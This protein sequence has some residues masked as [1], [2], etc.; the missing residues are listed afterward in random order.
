[1]LIADFLIAVGVCLAWAF[2]TIVSRIVVTGMDVPPLFYA[3]VRFALVA[4][5]TWPWLL[6]MPRP[7]W[8]LVAVG[9]LIGGASFALMFIGLT[10]ATASSSAIVSQLGVAMTTLLSIVILGEHVHWRRWL[11]IALTFAGAMVVMLDPS[12]LALS[13]GLIFV[14]ASALAGSL[15]A[16]LMKQ[17]EGVRPLQFQAWV[18]L[19]SFP[20]LTLMSAM[21]EN[22]PWTRA[23]AAGWPFLGALLF[24]GLVVSVLSHTAYYRLIQ[25]YDATV[26]APL[27]LMTPI[28]TVALGVMLTGDPIDVSMLIGAGL[29]L[30][31]VLIIALRKNHVMPLAILLRNRI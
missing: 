2:N 16:V 14:A 18:G 31:G 26:I 15:G 5:V 13:K 21:T 11:G 25:R 12:G 29:A 27:T 1:M 10:M 28:F 17:M 23:I 30:A 20:P 8:R 24:S 6:P 22:A 3:A 7:H 9:F 4:L 19:V